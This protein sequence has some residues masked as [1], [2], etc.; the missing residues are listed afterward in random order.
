VSAE[1]ARAELTLRWSAQRWLPV[2]VAFAA[3]TV[4]AQVS[5]PLLAGPA[6]TVSTVVTVVAF[7]AAS[8]SHAAWAFGPRAAALTGLCAA[9][10][11]LLSEAVG[12]ATGLP[13]GGYRYAASLGWQ[14]AGVPLVVPLA[15]TMMAYPAVL[16]ARLLARRPGEQPGEQAG[17][18]APSQRRRLVVALT[19]GW[20]LAAWD[21][22]LDPQMVSAGHWTWTSPQLHLPGVPGIPLSNGAGWLLVGTVIVA[23]LDR[24][25]PAV[26]RVPVAALPSPGGAGTPGHEGRSRGTGRPGRHPG[27]TWS[28]PFD[29]VPAALLAWTWLGSTLANLAFFDRPAVAGYGV[30]AMAVTVGPYLLAVRRGTR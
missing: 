27:M 16:L 21:L 11:G 10:L 8:L 18:T 25:L 13:F 3:L 15:W 2:S 26:P 6:L 1:T 12:V 7:A 9:G 5:Y 24:V 20:T 23:A 29:A 30:V 17:G 28:R 19:G 22:F 4:L 14:L